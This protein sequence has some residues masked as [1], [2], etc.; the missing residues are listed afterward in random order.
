MTLTEQAVKII[1][2]L[3]EISSTYM[4][5]I[6]SR[7]ERIRKLTNILDDRENKLQ[8]KIKRYESEIK[9]MKKQN[10]LF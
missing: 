3:D 6:H 9:A 8:A 4:K 7:D 1:H 10:N 5:L 2:E